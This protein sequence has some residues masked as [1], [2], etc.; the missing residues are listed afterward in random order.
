M[1]GYFDGAS[2]GNPGA[3]GAGALIA[4]DRGTA[5][6]ET[7][8]PLGVRT[9]NE[10]EYLALLLLLEEADRRGIREM[11]VFG[12]SRLV[13]SQ[14]S[15]LWKINEPRLRELAER[16]WALCEGKT[17]RFV[18]IPRERNTRADALSN[19]ALDGQKKQQAPVKWVHE[20]IAL[21]Q[22]PDGEVYAVDVRH[23]SC[24]CD[25]FGRTGICPHLDAVRDRQKQK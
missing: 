5:V 11:E 8:V 15:R 20:G 12:D 10:A 4:D 24:T 7:S 9:N 2:R 14:V 1:K 23:R 17:V 13:I 22:D 21:V 6:W 25:R 18:W 19:Q 3:A 16:V